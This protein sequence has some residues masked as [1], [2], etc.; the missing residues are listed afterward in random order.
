MRAGVRASVRRLVPDGR[1]VV[2]RCARSFSD[3]TQINIHSSQITQ[4]P[5]QGASQAMLYATGLN[6]EQLK[7][8]QV[9][10]ASVWWEGNPCNMHLLDLS[11]RVKEGCTDAGTIGL[12]FNT[13]GV[14]DAIS[15]GTSG[16][17]QR[18]HDSAFTSAP[19]QACRTACLLETSSR[20]RSR[21]LCGRSGTMR[22]S[23]Y[24][25]VTR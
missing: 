17:R 10:I 4:P 9:G 23:A 6:E 19:P 8:P 14:S 16:G 21:R 12:R 2:L 22:I 1:P 3:K 13:I 11:E 7:L 24:P 18:V 5:S 25:A 20:T 15:M